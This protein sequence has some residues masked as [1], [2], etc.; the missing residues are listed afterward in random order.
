[1]TNRKFH[2]FMKKPESVS[3]RRVFW[4]GDLRPVWKMLDYE[5]SDY[6]V[7]VDKDRDLFIRDM[8][9]DPPEYLAMVPLNFLL[10]Q[11]ETGEFK[12]Y[13]PEDFDAEFTQ[14]GGTKNEI[15]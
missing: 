4:T 3:L 11:F 2:V 1:M 10:V 8:N 5:R 9:S 6:R 13:H 7:S 15:L 12:V 14:G